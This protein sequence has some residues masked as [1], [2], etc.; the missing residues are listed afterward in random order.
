MDCKVHGL[1]KRQD[2]TEQLS[3]LGAFYSLLLSP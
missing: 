2:T 1:T 3:L